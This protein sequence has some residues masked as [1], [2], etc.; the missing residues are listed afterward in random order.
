[1]SGCVYHHQEVH[2]AAKSS[3]IAALGLTILKLIIGLQTNSLG[4]LAEAAHS[5]LDLLAAAITLGA[6][7]ISAIP[8]DHN[9]HYGHGKI[10]SIAALLEALLLWITCGWILYEVVARLVGKSNIEIEPS[11][12]SFAILVISILV[13][14]FRS[15]N[16]KKVA[17][18]Y[19]S[20]A[21]AADALHF[22]TDIYSSG[23]VLLGL[24]CASFGLHSA[25][26]VAATLV[27]AWSFFMSLK[28]ARESIDQ[29]MDKAPIGAE[30]QIK[31]ILAEITKIQ[32]IKE[33]RIRSSGAVTFIVL[34]I[35]LDRYMSFESVH[36]ITD[37]IE[38]RLV[39]HFSPASISIHAEPV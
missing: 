36:S 16:L 18:Q 31:K 15:R 9:H 35:G 28:L 37:L 25:D 19:N 12:W 1:M 29:L 26:S 2:K 34:T 13:D 10:E 30:E 8:A 22:Q 21:L 11:I 5:T 7:R 3:V 23:A 33:I 32:E 39:S 38:S 4:I 27:I 20:Q 6:V 14:W 17:L 24:V